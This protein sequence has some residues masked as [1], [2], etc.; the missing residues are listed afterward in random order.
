MAINPHA[1]K[2][3]ALRPQRTVPQDEPTLPML[4]PADFKR[5]L[6]RWNSRKTKGRNPR[7]NEWQECQ[8][9]LFS[10]GE[11]VRVALSNGQTFPS[12]GE[13]EYVLSLGGDFTV[14]LIDN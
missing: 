13:M 7:K 3:F 11:V 2:Y 8:G 9:V 12:Q 14:D 5:F 10:A 4:A 6:L 1:S